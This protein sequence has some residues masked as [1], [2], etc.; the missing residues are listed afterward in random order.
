MWV[1]WS[2]SQPW[3]QSQNTSERSLIDE[4]WRDRNFLNSLQWVVCDVLNPGSTG[5]TW[6]ELLTCCV[7]ICHSLPQSIAVAKMLH[8]LG[9]YFT[10]MCDLLIILY[11]TTQLKWT[12]QHNSSHFGMR[13]GFG[14]NQTPRLSSTTIFGLVNTFYSCST[15]GWTNFIFPSIELWFSVSQALGNSVRI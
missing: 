2:H 7:A 14:G 8:M 11:W 1:P 9:L 6:H 15:A 4:D 3:L 5:K 12:Q 13:K 10:E